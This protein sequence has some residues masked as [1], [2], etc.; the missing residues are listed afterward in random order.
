MKK[1][2][3]GLFAIFTGSFCFCQNSYSMPYIN[4]QPFAVFFDS[5]IRKNFHPELDTLGVHGSCWIKFTIAS[6]GKPIQLELSPGTPSQLEKEI[7]K[8]IS[9]TNGL[10]HYQDLNEWFIIPFQFTLQRNGKTK[11]LFIDSYSLFGFFSLDLYPKRRYTILQSL[12]FVSSF[13]EGINS[14]Q[15]LIQ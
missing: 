4:G 1:L 14:K 13:D 12:E 11:P 9:I 2:I 6:D 7:R 5:V 10:W 8:A 3:I 15:K